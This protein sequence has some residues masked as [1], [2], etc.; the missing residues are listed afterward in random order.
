MPHCIIEHSEKFSEI[1]PELLKKA[2][3]ALEESQLFQPQDI[4]ARSM[5]YAHSIVGGD[6]DAA[7]VHIKLTILSGRTQEQKQALTTA[8]GEGI[9]SLLKPMGTTSLTVAVQDISRE[10]YYKQLISRCGLSS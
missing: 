6:L 7:F 5:A 8:L 9:S 10:T 1:A 3:E 2:V 4:K